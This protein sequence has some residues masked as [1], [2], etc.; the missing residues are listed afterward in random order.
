MKQQAKEVVLDNNANKELLHSITEIYNQANEEH[1]LLLKEKNAR[2]A[3][4]ISEQK[5]MPKS[6][7]NLW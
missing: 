2:Y 3:E 1:E 7:L 5:K 6:R 4:Q